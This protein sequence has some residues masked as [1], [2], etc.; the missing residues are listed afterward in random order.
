MVDI[1]Y[2]HNNKTL[3]IAISMMMVHILVYITEMMVYAWLWAASVLVL[4]LILT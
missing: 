3:S 2:L 1:R 4:P